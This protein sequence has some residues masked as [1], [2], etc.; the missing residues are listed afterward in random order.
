MGEQ[1]CARCTSKMLRR[2]R[3]SQSPLSHLKWSVLHVYSAHKVVHAYVYCLQN[4]EL[5]KNYSPD[6][7][8]AV[9]VVLIM[10]ANFN[11]VLQSG[12]CG[13]MSMCTR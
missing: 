8:C 2:T 12:V 3:T 4:Y 7:Y 6:K 10:T 1:W 13:R 9:I 5:L 11:T